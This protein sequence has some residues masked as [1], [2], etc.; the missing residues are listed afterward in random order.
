MVYTRRH[1]HP[2]FSLIEIVVAMMII[3]L[4]A[5]VAVPL[6]MRYAESAKESTTKTNL[7]VLK[8]SVDL[9]KIEQGKYPTKLQDLVERPKGLTGSW[10]PYLEKLPVDGWKSEFYYRVNAGGSTHPYDL[11]SYGSNGPEAGIPEERIS[12]WEI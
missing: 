2:G 1:M 8:S 7:K 6:Y 9:F 10:K 11:Y 3:G 12:V 5:G 4:L